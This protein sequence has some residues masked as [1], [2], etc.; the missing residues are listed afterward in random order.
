[1]AQ[2]LGN[3]F[4]TL[5]LT[6]DESKC[7]EVSETSL[8]INVFSVGKYLP[9]KL[10]KFWSKCLLCTETG[11]SLISGSLR[12]VGISVSIIISVK[13]WSR[14]FWFCLLCLPNRWISLSFVFST[15]LPSSSRCLILLRLSFSLTASLLLHWAELSYEKRSE[16]LMLRGPWN[17][18]SIMPVSNL[19]SNVCPILP[20]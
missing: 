8:N 20:Y 19:Y 13:L 18:Y 5:I 11:Y 17:T 16:W 12:C 10:F 9:V 6:G 7:E 14:L 2:G 3:N 15:N 1:M 4:T